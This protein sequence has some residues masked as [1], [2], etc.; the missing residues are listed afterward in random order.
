MKKFMKTPASNYQE[1][2]R[3]KTQNKSMGIS[4]L[5]NQRSNEKHNLPNLE[6]EPPTPKS[7]KN[8]K[9]FNSTNSNPKSKFE[10]PPTQFPFQNPLPP[11]A[12]HNA[13]F[14]SSNQIQPFAQPIPPTQSTPRLAPPTQ[15]AQPTNQNQPP[16]A[17]LNPF[18]VQPGMFKSAA[19]VKGQTQLD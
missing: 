4:H 18:I 10:I 16:F 12:N 2:N 9:N 11:V 19:Q 13:A 6:I 15:F 7:S 3:E 8:A 1:F 14:S 17:L 5:T